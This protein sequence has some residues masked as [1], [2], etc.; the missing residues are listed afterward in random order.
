MRPRRPPFRS[1]WRALRSWRGA[2]CR[3]CWPRTRLSACSPRCS[4]TPRRP[5][6]SRWAPFYGGNGE[7]AALRARAAGAV[8]CR[9][10]DP[11]CLR[12]LMARG[13]AV[14]RLLRASNN[15]LLTRRCLPPP[16]AARADPSQTNVTYNGSSDLTQEI[17]LNGGIIEWENDLWKARTGNVQMAWGAQAS[18]PAPRRACWPVRLRCGGPKLALWSLHEHDRPRA[19]HAACRRLKPA[20]LPR[21]ATGPRHGAPPRPA[22]DPG[23]GVC[24]Q[25]APHVGHVAGRLQ[26][27]RQVSG[28]SG[29][30]AGTVHARAVCLRRAGRIGSPWQSRRGSRIASLQPH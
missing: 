21:V 1:S 15:A 17:A 10:G 24:R 16:H 22:H 30:G 29:A 12:R 19:V 25:E 4:T 28:L 11:C 7:A 13:G 8:C 20:C 5:R 23:R 3:R 6:P 26:A 9:P 27:P 14:H 2:T 18:A